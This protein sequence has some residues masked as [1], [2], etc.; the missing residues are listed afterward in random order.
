MPQRKP[1]ANVQPAFLRAQPIPGAVAASGRR[2]HRSAL[3]E[4]TGSVRAAA[5]PAV[6]TEPSWISFR[7]ADGRN[8]LTSV[9]G[10]ETLMFFS[11]ERTTGLH[12]Q[13]RNFLRLG[14]I[15]GVIL[16]LALAWT[17]R[18]SQWSSW[19]VLLPLPFW[20]ALRFPIEQRRLLPRLVLHCGACL[21]LI[22]G[23]QIAG[24]RALALG[25]GL[26]P[27]FESTRPHFQAG[28]TLGPPVRRGPPPFVWLIVDVLIYGTIVSLCQ[29][30]VSSQRAAARE[31]QALVAE[32]GLAQAKL[33]AL[34]MQLN[35]HFL[36]NALNGISTLIHLDAQAADDRLGDLSELLRAVLETTG[37]AEISLRRELDFLRRILAIEKA[38]FGER[39]DSVL[40]IAPEVL[41]AFVPTFI[42]QPLCE[43]AIKHGIESR[44]EGG[45]VAITARR[46]NER[47]ILEFG[48]SGKGPGAKAAPGHGIGLTN[49]RARLEALY[50]K[51]H[52]LTIATTAGGCTVTMALPFHLAPLPESAVT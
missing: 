43:N 8:R 50:P 46:E 27:A 6:R 49:T 40:D 42:L 19:I 48:D 39:L 31:R 32:A 25:Q 44:L 13:R 26:R 3:P 45:R 29:A 30:I 22:A 37:E 52:A 47:L 2:T 51:N 9:R 41:D 34:Q 18:W 5:G 17:L 12:S 4:L 10:V 36:F 33:A 21:L 1:A 11:K 14:L 20:L 35:P 23:H 24:R 28:A 16:W 38:R 7:G 15:F